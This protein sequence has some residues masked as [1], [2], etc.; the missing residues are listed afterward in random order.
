MQLALNCTKPWNCAFI[1]MYHTLTETSEIDFKLV[2]NGQEY[3][4]L[5]RDPSYLLLSSP[6]GGQWS[7]D[8]S[9]LFY[10]T[11]WL[12]ANKIGQQQQLES[13]YSGFIS[14][15]GKDSAVLNLIHNIIQD[16]VILLKAGADFSIWA[17]DAFLV[18][19]GVDST[20][21]I[22]PDSNA[23]FEVSRRKDTAMADWFAKTDPGGF[24][25][26]RSDMK[27]A[28]GNVL[29]GPDF[30]LVGG[31][32]VANRDGSVS[33]AVL[34][35]LR[36]M[37]DKDIIPLMSDVYPTSV[38][39]DWADTNSRIQP[40]LLGIHQPFYHIDLFVTLAGKQ[41]GKYRILVGKVLQPDASHKAYHPMVAATVD[42]VNARI[43]KVIEGL[44]P[45]MFSIHRVPMSF[46]YREDGFKRTWYF[47]TYN[48]CLIQ[49]APDNN[50]VWM[51]TYG[52]GDW[53]DLAPI[54]SQAAAVYK[55][56]GFTVH[57]LPNCTDLIHLGG[58]VHCLA[59]C[60]KRERRNTDSP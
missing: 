18:M 59:K 17:Q 48:N 7:K 4:S 58:A 44:D 8:L 33:T 24:K 45:E 2:M 10:K 40:G 9:G 35:R 26:M 3:Q 60:L 32:I 1:N 41:D 13:L 46:T 36:A 50:A 30:V 53:E 21:L 31:D 25:V 15:G 56:L 39:N 14:S 22:K 55:S 20:L 57:R 11:A 37:S 52:Y 12:A 5:V 6:P 51:P 49:V 43:E 16:K 47:T 34:E 28:G 38:V 29:I 42:A 23:L 54:D 19:D 27:F